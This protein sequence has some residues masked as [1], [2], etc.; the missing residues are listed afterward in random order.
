MMSTPCRIWIQVC[1]FF[2][3]IM[4]FQSA[5]ISNWLMVGV[6]VIGVWCMFLLLKGNL[7]GLRLYWTMSAT[8][9]VINLMHGV[10]LIASCLNLIDPAILTFFVTRNKQAFH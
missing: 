9:I 1:F 2:N 4:I 7:L 5:A 3:I 10:N 6:S 8:I